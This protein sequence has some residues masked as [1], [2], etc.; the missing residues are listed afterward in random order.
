MVRPVQSGWATFVRHL[1][2]RD[3]AHARFAERF[4]SNFLALLNRFVNFLDFMACPLF[5]EIR[6]E[7]AVYIN[8]LPTTR[9]R[10]ARG[11]ALKQERHPNGYDNSFHSIRFTFGSQGSCVKRR[12]R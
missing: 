1:C 9:S 5:F 6:R 7:A 8:F 4:S 3:V 11:E 12:R 2:D 10:F